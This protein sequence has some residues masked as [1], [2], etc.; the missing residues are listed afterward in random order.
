MSNRYPLH[1]VTVFQGL[2]NILKLL[3]IMTK[4]CLFTEGRAQASVLSAMQRLWTW[5]GAPLLIQSET[6]K[7]ISSSY[8]HISVHVRKLWTTFRRP[9]I[10]IGKNIL[11]KKTHFALPWIMAVL[12]SASQIHSSHSYSSLTQL[13]NR[14]FNF[15]RGIK[16]FLSRGHEFSSGGTGL[17]PLSTEGLWELV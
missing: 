2:N 15:D 1:Q 16:Q 12:K 8:C 17:P 11:D 14:P 9:E 13:G 4:V 6:I 7:K 5:N 10:H 3:G